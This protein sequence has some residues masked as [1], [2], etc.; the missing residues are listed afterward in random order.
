MTPPNS[1]GSG[2]HYATQVPR[3]T[4]IDTHGTYPR[5]NAPSSTSAALFG[6]VAAA[7]LISCSP[8]GFVGIGGVVMGV[9]AKREIA[10]SSGRYGGNGLAAWGV[11]GGL[12]GILGA[13]ASLFLFLWIVFPG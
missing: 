11:V 1:T 3:Q 8:L 13:T 9:E 6:T 5:P 10:L 2:E 12:I 4:T 7:S